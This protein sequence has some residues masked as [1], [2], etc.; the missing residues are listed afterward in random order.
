MTEDVMK[1]KDNNVDE[2][3]IVPLYVNNDGFL[4]L[5]SQMQENVI[6]I[7]NSIVEP[8]VKMQESIRVVASN[9]QDT[10]KTASNMGA[11]VVD[12]MQPLQTFASEYK[13]SA[14]LLS[15]L[16]QST[17]ENL[18]SFQDVITDFPLQATSVYIDPLTT[19]DV[20]IESATIIDTTPVSGIS[21]ASVARQKTSIGV[22]EFETEQ[23][24]VLKVDRLEEKVDTV[25][26]LL[27]E[28]IYPFLIEDSKRK[29]NLLDEILAYYKGKPNS[30]VKV[31]N[32]AFCEGT[33]KLTIDNH[34]IPLLPDTN[35]EM[36]CRVVFKNKKALIKLW[37]MDEIVEAMG[38]GIEQ[39]KYW[40]RRL[41]QTARQLN[42][43][44]AKET[45]LKD[46]IVYTTKTIC[47]NPIF[48]KN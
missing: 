3:N 15:D 30:F 35:E 21:L 18:V 7:N 44:I 22:L 10:V 1:L 9:L 6:A 26:N 32:V 47:V 14:V 45:G 31:N 13:A 12:A 27:A 43:K 42:D 5:A 24:L 20:D 4:S 17:K 11:A 25:Q 33:C 48:L 36:L 29:D 38:E 28:E 34:E 23:A 19:I 40:K 16:V 39:T 8:V 37:Y 2:E 46:F 41:Y